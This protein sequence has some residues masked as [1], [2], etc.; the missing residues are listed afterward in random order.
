MAQVD[1]AQR[2]LLSLARAIN[3]VAVSSR[4]S[5]RMLPA[6]APV[7]SMPNALPLLTFSTHPHEHSRPWKAT[8]TSKDL[9]QATHEVDHTRRRR[10]LAVAAAAGAHLVENV[11][12]S[13]KLLSMMTSTTMDERC[14]DELLLKSRGSQHQ[15]HRTGECIVAS[16]TRLCRQ[17]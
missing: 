16:G 14:E 9:Q 15:C 12:R 3:H 13:E 10:Q 5:I 1:R 8:Q 7:E 2:L 6:P 4:D 11:I 17:R